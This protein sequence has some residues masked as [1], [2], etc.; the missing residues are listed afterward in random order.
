[1]NL[2]LIVCIKTMISRALNPHY[3]SIL[4]NKSRTVKLDVAAGKSILAAWLA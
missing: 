3:P 2:Y 1:M 4:G